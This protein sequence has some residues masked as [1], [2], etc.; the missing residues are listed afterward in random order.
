MTQTEFEKYLDVRLNLIKE[1]LVSKRKEYADN[2]NVFRNF[3]VAADISNQ[4]VEEVMR[5]Y[6]LKHFVSYLDI[7]N[8]IKYSDGFPTKFKEDFI[9]EKFGDIINYMILTEIYILA[10]RTEDKIPF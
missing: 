2:S 5:N 6:M 8:T 4:K 10:N 9:K 1:V 7:I 3:E